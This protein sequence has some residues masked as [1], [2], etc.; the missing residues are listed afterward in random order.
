MVARSFQFEPIVEASTATVGGKV[1]AIQR[2][3][4]I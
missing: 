3:A 1:A 2:A 4:A